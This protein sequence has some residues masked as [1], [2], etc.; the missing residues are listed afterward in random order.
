MDGAE[1]KEEMPFIRPSG[2]QQSSLRMDEVQQAVQG[3][4]AI[5]QSTRNGHERQVPLHSPIVLDAQLDTCLLRL[6]MT[7]FVDVSSTDFLTK[8][9]AQ[10]ELLRG[11]ANPRYVALSPKHSRPIPTGDLAQR[12]HSRH[13]IVCA[14]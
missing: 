12:T 7:L 8:L 2:A 10:P 5:G 9:Q 3:A 13:V 6:P 14:S 1:E 11:L 4:A